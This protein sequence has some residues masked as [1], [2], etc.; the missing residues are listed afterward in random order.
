MNDEAAMLEA[1]LANPDDET[2]LLV[3]ADWLEERGDPRGVNI[4]ANVELSQTF[5]VGD[6]VRIK[7]GPFAG[8]EAR[9]AGINSAR[10][11]AGLHLDLFCRQTE[12]VSVPLSDLDR[13][14]DR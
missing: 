12:L 14:A 4:R 3:Y 13:I 9:I 7:T 10:A 8:I 5:R 11:Q 2:Q 1:I 6:Y